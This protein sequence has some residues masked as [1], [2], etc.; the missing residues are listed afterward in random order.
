MNLKRL[1]RRAGFHL[2]RNLAALRARRGMAAVAATGDRLG[3]W[4]HR[5]ARGQR[6]QLE[7]QLCR[8]F[9]V[10]TSDPGPA[11]WLEDAY[12]INDRAIFEILA[13]Y[14]GRMKI[15]EVAEHCAVDQL[16]VLD[17]A[18]EEGRGVVLLG[19]HM[20]NGVSMAT[21]LAHL[22]Y[23][24]SVVFRESRKIQPEFYPRGLGFMGLEA[25]GAQPPAVGFRRMLKA[26]KQNRV[27]YIL[28]DQG[29]KHGIET[30][31]LGKRVPM[32]PGPAELVRRTGCALVTAPLRGVDPRWQFGLERVDIIDPQEELE[33]SVEK[34]SRI[35]ENQILE[36]PEW[37]TWHQRRWPRYPFQDSPEQNPARRR[38]KTHEDL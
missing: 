3:R 8:L 23:P 11:A 14:S 18:L 35:M 4:H 22:G 28:M 36:R 26:L 33:A 2:L 9:G 20:G 17:Q 12:R 7:Q 13:M 30:P 19:W 34:L 15:A 1:R 10:E 25:I 27:I 38:D 5:L 24:I 29:I 21:R 6:R 32:P 37:W 16:Q 31:F